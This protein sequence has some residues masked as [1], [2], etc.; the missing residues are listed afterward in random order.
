MQNGHSWVC[1]GLAGDLDLKSE[2]LL[3]LAGENMTHRFV[4]VSFLISGFRCSD[5][6]EAILFVGISKSKGGLWA[7]SNSTRKYV[8][9][10]VSVSFITIHVLHLHIVR[11]ASTNFW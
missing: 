9:V 4:T 10:A 8:V 7:K 1:F 3:A 6:E 11:I 2:G 5:S